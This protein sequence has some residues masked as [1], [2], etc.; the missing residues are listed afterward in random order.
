MSSRERFATALLGGVAILLLLPAVRALF[1]DPGY[2]WAY[3]MLMSF[4]VSA[5]PHCSSERRFATRRS[6]GFPRRATFKM[7]IPC[8]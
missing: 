1:V 3:V 2:R 4:C 8:H 7:D 5:E 6:T